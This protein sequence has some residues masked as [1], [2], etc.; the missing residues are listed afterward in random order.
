MAVPGTAPSRRGALQKRARARTRGTLSLY[1][2]ISSFFL[3][4]INLA[5]AYRAGFTDPTLN[6]S[7]TLHAHINT[8]VHARMQRTCATLHGHVRCGSAVQKIERSPSACSVRLI[9]VIRL[10]HAR[11]SAPA[12]S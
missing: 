1:I 3:T 7:R 6:R 5:E 9:G 10:L 8:H 11:T 2:L 12:S 4:L